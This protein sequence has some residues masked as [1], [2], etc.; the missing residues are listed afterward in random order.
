M[1]K[2]GPKHQEMIHKIDPF[3]YGKR[4]K[5]LEFHCVTKYIKLN[6]SELS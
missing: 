1:A 3:Q 5:L 6:Y 4:R 2:L